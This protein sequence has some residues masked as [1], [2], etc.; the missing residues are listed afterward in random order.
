MSSLLLLAVLVGASPEAPS[1]LPRLVV[2]DLSAAGGVAR[3]EAASFS[4]QVTAEVA[5]RGFF[6]V[7]SSRDIATLLGLERQKALLGCSDAAA[8]CM[9][10]LTGA[11]DARYVMSGTVSRV[12]ENFQLSVQT[13][14]A[15]SAQPL[16][17]SLRIARSL[18]EL[19][20]AVP[21]LVAESTGTPRPPAPS[22]VLPIS[23]LVAGGAA[24]V[25]GG[26]VGFNALTREAVA[27][28]ELARGDSQR[29]TL[30]PLGYYRD[31]ARAVSAY[32][33]VSAAALGL[34]AALVVT[35]ALLMP[36]DPSE[37]GVALVPTANGAALVGSF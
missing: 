8:A 23:L 17:R 14:D 29:G 22:R 30:Q 36:K 18:D 20:R 1:G 3:D 33:T 6:Q 19:R 5:A 21:F 15:R 11:L 4:E 16:G 24:V 12:G 32:K 27:N 25:A 28:A 26:V 34:G 2:L 31:E 35:G 13:L 7:V 9:T 37:T 10:E